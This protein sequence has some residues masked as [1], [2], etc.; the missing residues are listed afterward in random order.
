MERM[1]IDGEKCCGCVNVLEEFR[2]FGFCELSIVFE[3]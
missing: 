3:D 1:L 2:F